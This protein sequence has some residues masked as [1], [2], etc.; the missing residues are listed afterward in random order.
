MPIA[1]FSRINIWI[2]V[3]LYDV[4]QMTR[5]LEEI[6]DGK[7]NVDFSAAKFGICHEC[8]KV[9][10]S[11]SKTSDIVSSKRE[12]ELYDSTMSACLL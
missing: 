7:G 12:A 8:E 6:F 10:S 11:A 1:V 9:N 2:I 3:C 5:S 4:L